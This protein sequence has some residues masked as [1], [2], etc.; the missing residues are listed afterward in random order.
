MTLTESRRDARRKQTAECFTPPDLVRQMLSKL[1]HYSR[2]SWQDPTFTFC[3]PA[4]GNGNMLVEVLK[5]KIAKGHDPSEALSTLYG[6]DIKRDN[7]RECRLRLLRVVSEQGVQI[8][9]D[10]VRTVFNHIV[11]TPLD[12]YP[13]GSLDYDF[14]F[15]DRAHSEDIDRWLVGIQEGNWLDDPS[16]TVKSM[17]GVDDG[18]DDAVSDDLL[19]M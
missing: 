10:H 16:G 8:T 19:A 2:K 1:A 6:C 15:L 12:R 18:I 13:N 9:Y 14:S 3:D 5:M 17:D 7:I 4:C 11:L